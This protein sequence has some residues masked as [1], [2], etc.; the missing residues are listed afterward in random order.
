MLSTSVPL[1]VDRLLSRYTY[2]IT[3]GNLYSPLA[4]L[5]RVTGYELVG[6]RFES[7][8]GRYYIRVAQLEEQSLDK[9]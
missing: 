9:R 8:K 7:C 2:N 4:Q 3:D 1:E 5:D 6:R